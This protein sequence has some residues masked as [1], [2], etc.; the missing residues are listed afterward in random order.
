MA[1]AMPPP[2]AT[3]STAPAK[4]SATRPAVMGRS[5]PWC[6][7]S[8]RSDAMRRHVAGWPLPPSSQISS[9]SVPF[10]RLVA[11]SWGCSSAMPSRAAH[12]SPNPD[13]A[14][15]SGTLSGS[16]PWSAR[17]MHRVVRR[18]ALQRHERRRD[19]LDS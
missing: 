12:V 8:V 14:V 9:S 16:P 15:S 4:K 17:P 19:A 13:S 10:A 6:T 2:S 7:P 18:Q 1:S 11:A 3:A 5:S